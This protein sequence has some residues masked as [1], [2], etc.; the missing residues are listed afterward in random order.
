MKRAVEGKRQKAKGKRQKA[1]DGFRIRFCR[2]SVVC[3]EGEQA[4]NVRIASVSITFAFCLLPFAFCLFSST[5]PPASLSH[6]T[7]AWLLKQARA[8]FSGK[9]IDEASA[10]PALT[11]A[12]PATLFVTTFRRGHASPPLAG[13]GANLLAA[14]RAALDSSNINAR[15]A[16]SAPQAIA[17]LSPRTAHPTAQ[18]QA[19][20]SP[21]ANRS[22]GSS[23]TPDRIQIDILDGELAPLEK[24]AETEAAARLS[25]AQLIQPGS[26]GIAIEMQGRAFYLPP[27]HLIN[28]RIF[29]DDADRQRAAD[30][31]DRAVNY[32][33]VKDWRAA[34]VRLRRF[35][36]F[37]FV[38]DRSH[39]AA[40]DLNASGTLEEINRARLNRAAQAGGDYLI[41]AQKRDGSFHY[42][43]DPFVESASGRDYNIL[44]HAGAAM[45]LFQLYEAT[46]EARYLEAARRAVVYLKS[47]FQ[48]AREADTL[49][50]LD[51]DGKAKLG[52]NGLALI[53]LAMQLRLDPK[54]GDQASA[55]RL[56]NLILRMQERDG[57]FASYYTM[58]GESA[59]RASLYYPGEALLGLVELYSLTG[60]KRLI[61][62]AR[63]GADYLIEIQ[64]RMATLPP[65]AWLMQ[66]L[67][68][69]FVIKRDTTYAAH[70]IRLAE[71]MMREQ[72]TAEGAPLY[73]GG[74]RPGVPRATPAASRAE[75]MLA[76]LRLARLTN[77]GRAARI[78]EALKLSARFQLAQQFDADN[79][80]Y[81]ANPERVVGG[82]RESLTSAR[83][84]IDYVQHNI[85]ALLGIAQIVE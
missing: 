35:R 42:N 9:V 4:R 43:Y 47:R 24:P 38:E 64:E 15:P 58:K 71:A 32:L 34:E 80:F 60:D 41:R 28:N 22:A 77:D 67:E 84:R 51:D 27:S 26:E 36:T 79:S 85:S 66:A 21:P 13:S 1:K 10:P 46:R 17:R 30:L 81:L 31:L 78:A 69:L 6:E 48:W 73:A 49:Y 76:A 59:D 33:A 55:L 52:A 74:Y 61:E 82:F 20:S 12:R 72:Y 54:S 39:Q 18:A 16:S 70:A 29:A 75:G 19:D 83:I 56:A 7:G 8:R 63:R 14:L 65:D 50:V 37:A 40:I 11:M 57:S 62:A 44:R 53:T 3:G 45:A 2:P 68:A 25:A 5:A 23:A